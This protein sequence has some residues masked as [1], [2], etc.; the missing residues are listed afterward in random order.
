MH[1]V[2]SNAVAEE[3]NN[4]SVKYI[5]INGSTDV[6]GNLL[7]NIPNIE[8]NIAVCYAGSG[9]SDVNYNIFFSVSQGKWYIHTSDFFTG[10]KIEGAT[11]NGR[12]YYVHYD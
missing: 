9:G 12:V 4:N 7:V 5:E 8:E 11:V 10:Q 3:I 1:S 2:T 6:S